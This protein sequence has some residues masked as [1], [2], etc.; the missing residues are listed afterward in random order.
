V[1]AAIDVQVIRKG[2]VIMWLDAANF[3]PVNV[4]QFKGLIAKAYARIP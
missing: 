1:S 4:A 2:G 3:P